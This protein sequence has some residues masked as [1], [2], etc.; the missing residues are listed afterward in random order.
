MDEENS[1]LSLHAVLVVIRMMIAAGA[2]TALVIQWNDTQAVIE[3]ASGV[4]RDASAV[5]VIQAYVQYFVAPAFMTIGIAVCLY[6][7]TR[8]D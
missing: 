6:I 4:F 3:A 5:Q 7:G 2:I 8:W 1:G